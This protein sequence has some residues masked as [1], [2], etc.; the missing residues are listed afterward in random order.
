MTTTFND[1]KHLI[2]TVQR[3]VGRVGRR[4]DE[5]SPMVDA[6]LPDGSRII[7]VIPPLARDGSLVS[8]RRFSTKPMQMSDLVQKNAIAPE[9]VDFLAAFIR[10]RLTLI[11]LALAVSIPTTFLLWL[12][13]WWQAGF[14]KRPGHDGALCVS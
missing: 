2:Q 12:F 14:E 1:E 8:I 4:V 7:A 11:T 10:A 5:T 9:M 6:R 13:F 3:M